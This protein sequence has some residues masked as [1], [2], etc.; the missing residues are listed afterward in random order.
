[1]N[2]H[3]FVANAVRRHRHKEAVIA[4][5]G[6]REGER[7]EGDADDRVDIASRD[8]FPASDPPGWIAQSVRRGA[9]TRRK[10]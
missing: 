7:V 8:S 1:M 10:S 6:R 9:S 2:W 4:S 3:D 5:L